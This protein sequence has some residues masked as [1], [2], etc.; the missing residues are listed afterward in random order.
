M[1]NFIYNTITWL[2]KLAILTSSR[3]ITSLLTRIL[4]V[5]WDSNYNR[6]PCD[7][8]WLLNNKMLILTFD[9]SLVGPISPRLLGN[10]LYTIINH[11]ECNLLGKYLSVLIV[12]EYEGDHRTLSTHFNVT[13]STT[14][15]QFIRHFLHLTDIHGHGESKVVLTN[16]I[17]LEV[18]IVATPQTTRL[19][20][21]NL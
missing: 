7:V 11:P 8:K 5:N 19:T 20:Q 21:S 4:N 3:V 15:E 10:I 9:L 17:F 1:I 18:K 2:W 6:L 13:P 16:A 12:A 14:P